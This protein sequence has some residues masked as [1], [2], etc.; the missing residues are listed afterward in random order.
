MWT[1]SICES[2]VWHCDMYSGRD[3]ELD[4]LCGEGRDL[5]L[6]WRF[7]GLLIPMRH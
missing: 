2:T 1:V 3:W 7:T 4:T 5:G 6:S